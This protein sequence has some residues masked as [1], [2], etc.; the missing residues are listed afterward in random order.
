MPKAEE[1]PSDKPHARKVADFG[2]MTTCNANL[3][4][5]LVCPPLPAGTIECYYI[6]EPTCTPINV[7]TLCLSD[8]ELEQARR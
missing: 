2:T 6:N 7:R 5:R 4:L 8:A 1:C 3:K